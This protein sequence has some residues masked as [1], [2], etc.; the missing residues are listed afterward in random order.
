[1][2]FVQAHFLTSYA[3]SNL[4]RD[5]TG[6]NKTAIFGGEERL[7]TSS[8]NRKYWVREDFKLLKGDAALPLGVR[9][10][11]FAVQ[12]R[13][14]LVDNGVDAAAAGAAAKAVLSAINGKEREKKAEEPPAEKPESKKNNRRKPGDAAQ[15][16]LN[17]ESAALQFLS[18]TE[19]SRAYAAAEKLAR[20]PGTEVKAEDVL[21]HAD[22]AVDIAMF[23]R[24]FAGNPSYNREAAVQVMHAITVH[25]ATVEDDYFTALG[26]HRTADESGAVHVGENAFGSGVFY[27]YL[28]VNRALLISNLGGDATLAD[29]AIAALIRSFATVTPGGKRSNFAAYSYASYVRIEKGNGQPR[30]LAGAFENAIRGNNIMADAVER[31][32]TYAAKIDAVY[33]LT[34][35]FRDVFVDEV[36]VTKPAETTEA[37]SPGKT[38][39]KAKA[40][41]NEAHPDT[42]A[43]AL[44]AEVIAFAKAA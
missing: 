19:I 27:A 37:A 33:G 29:K 26:D 5:D 35:E 7:R 32:R 41:A 2:N 21:L 23:G 16:S 8:Q 39:A 11:R 22:T 14:A 36:E 1:M 3:P 6:R 17:L 25:A 10:D 28:C 31:L 30:T 34:T 9:G 13:D 15:G 38:K 18:Q 4:N 42:K 24:T 12:I 20:N 40:A 44:L 43:R